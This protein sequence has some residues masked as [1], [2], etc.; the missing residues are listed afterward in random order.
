MEALLGR[1]PEGKIH[2]IRGPVFNYEG[3]PGWDLTAR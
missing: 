1:L 3:A 2:W